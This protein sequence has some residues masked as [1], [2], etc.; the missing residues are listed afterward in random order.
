MTELSELR[1]RLRCAAGLKS[2]QRL[3]PVLGALRPEV[4]AAWLK[5]ASL[6]QNGDDAA[7]LP[8]GEGY[9]LFAAEGIVPSFVKENPWFAGFSSVMVNVNDIA[10]MGGV[11]YAVVDVLFESAEVDNKRLLQGLRDG[12]AAFGV[13]CVGGHTGRASAAQSYLSVAI[14]GRAKRLLSA[15]AA[16]PGHDLIAA[17]DLRG[18]YRGTLNQFN[19]ATCASS[20]QLRRQLRVLPM[21]AEEGLASAAK[22]ISQAGLLGTLLMLCETSGVGAELALEQ[23]PRPPE[24]DL[25]RWLLSFPSFGFILSTEAHNT[26]SAL[27]CF[28]R[29]GVAARRVGHVTNAPRVT[30]TQG[31]S[32]ALFWNLEQEPLMGVRSVHSAAP[33]TPLTRQPPDVA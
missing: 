32:S 22:D 3:Q 19:A 25:E 6:I 28:E 27:R 26:E 30:V 29:V 17:I 2:K 31:E 24:V 10:A 11:P 5:D 21:L 20:E 7:V 8:E 16:K 14:I 23:V 15:F 1:E 12:A 4:P 13:P 18:T 33:R 9:L